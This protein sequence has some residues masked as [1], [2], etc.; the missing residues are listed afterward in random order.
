M[1]QSS[2]P[3]EPLAEYLQPRF[4]NIYYNLSEANTVNVTATGPLYRP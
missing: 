4:G 1:M 3:L 2:T